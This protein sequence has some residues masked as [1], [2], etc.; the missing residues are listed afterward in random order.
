M[1]HSLD[2]REQI[3]NVLAERLNKN[4]VGAPLNETL[5]EILHKLYTIGE[6]ELGSKLPFRPSTAADLAKATGKC[7]SELS[8][9]FESMANK[10]LVIDF[11]RRGETYY[12]LTPMVV[13][14]FEYTF[15]RAKRADLSEL[16]ELFEN[17]MQDQTVRQEIFHGGTKLFRAL[18][19]ESVLPLAVET[20]VLDFD[21]ASEII[22]KSGGGALSTCACRHMADHLGKACDAPIDDICASLGAASDWLIRR[23]FARRTTTEELLQ[24]LERAQKAGLVMLCDNV[25]GQPAFICFCCGC[26]CGVLRAINEGG[27]KAVEPGNFLP[28]VDLEK[29]IA[30][31]VCESACHV[32]AISLE[33]STDSIIPHINRELCIGCGVCAAVCS[34]GACYMLPRETRYEPPRDSFQQMLSIAREKNRKVF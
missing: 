34:A 8:H 29:C 27:L 19:Y 3:Y 22:R 6:A 33:S 4:P 25:L 5:M 28:E 23:D 30:C 31:G 1:G 17:Y 9:I 14:F 26:C 13:G 24:N 11:P 12:M 20:E 16:A 32:N 21:R 7:E 18:A 2:H 10:G 15:M